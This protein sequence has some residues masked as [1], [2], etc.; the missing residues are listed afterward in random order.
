VGTVSFEPVPQLTWEQ[1]REENMSAVRWWSLDELETTEMPFAP[2]R[3]PLLVR[4]LLEDGP[5]TVPVDVGV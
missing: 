4:S 1:L 5:P 2:R 3:L